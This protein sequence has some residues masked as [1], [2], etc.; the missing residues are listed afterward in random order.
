M[1][2]LLILRGL[3]ASG[4]STW[5]RNITTD[6]PHVA[7]VSLDG[8]RRMMAGSL[9][10]YHKY[11]T[12][13]AEQLVVRT[14]HAMVCDAL[15]KGLN[16]VMDAQNASVERVHELVRL[17]ADCDANVQVR[18]FTVPL[19]TLLKRNHNRAQDDRVP[20][21]YLRSQY[22]RFADNIA[23]PMQ[24][25]RVPVEPVGGHMWQP[26][27][28]GSMV[29][30]VDAEAAYRM[31]CK[32]LSVEAFRMVEAFLPSKYGRNGT[33]MLRIPGLGDSPMSSDAYNEWLRCGAPC[34]RMNDIPRPNPEPTLLDRM[35]AN[36]SVRV[37]PVRGEV[38]T[39]WLHA[40][41]SHERGE[42]S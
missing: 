18:A 33:N 1:V 12:D 17:A 16:V 20:E 19:E 13:R 28:H 23:T 21:D 7:I 25:V 36:P 15:R 27:A 26:S 41:S 10:S 9:T 29:A 38:V 42:K 37:K 24:W 35:C 4:K 34:L 30:L 39:A 14:A 5:A 31:A 8:L 32:P 6:D 3:P 2:T 40:C 22:E 11:R